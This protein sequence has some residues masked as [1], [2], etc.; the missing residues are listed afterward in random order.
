[1]NKRI[2]GYEAHES[3]EI[4]MKNDVKPKRVDN[5]HEETFPTKV[6]ETW[7]L[8]DVRPERQ[9][10]AAKKRRLKLMHATKNLHKI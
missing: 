7:A 4:A 1:M 3:K 8:T 10:V 6:L 9:K 5:D 2:N